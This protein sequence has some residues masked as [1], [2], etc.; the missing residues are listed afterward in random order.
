MGNHMH[1]NVEEKSWCTKWASEFCTT[2]VNTSGSVKG[3]SKP[4][5]KHA[6]ITFKR[7]VSI[8]IVIKHF[9]K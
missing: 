8:M 2:K 9:I 6:M 5:N 1:G 3:I 4:C 7:N